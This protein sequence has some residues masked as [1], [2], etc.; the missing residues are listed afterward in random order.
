[1][2]ADTRRQR[3][4][5]SA[6]ETSQPGQ[7][8]ARPSPPRRAAQPQHEEPR[9]TNGGGPP[10]PCRAADRR[11]L[12]RHA[13]AETLSALRALT[14]QRPRVPGPLP[15]EPHPL[16]YPPAQPEAPLCG[17]QTTAV[18]AGRQAQ[19]EQPQHG[20]RNRGTRAIRKPRKRTPALA[21]QH[22]QRLIAGRLI[23]CRIRAIQVVV[24]LSRC[25]RMNISPCKSP[26]AAAS[27][28]SD[29]LGSCRI[30]WDRLSASG[31]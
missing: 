9:P 12:Q 21:T 15:L 17:A 25:A 3:H 23:T 4:R 10:R 31:S 11:P 7:A 20:D 1:M 29:W 24:E 26:G 14:S 8:P 13:D 30:A 19:T 18:T 22:Q 5:P 2:S 27:T 28:S 6:K 16:P